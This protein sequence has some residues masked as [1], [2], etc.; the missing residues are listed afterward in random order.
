MN[1]RIPDFEDMKHEND[2][3]VTSLVT[4]SDFDG[5]KQVS[6][7]GVEYWSARDVRDLLKY[8]AWR[9]FLC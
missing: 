8:T 9:S 2:Q 6:S 7:Q 1:L 4:F 5:I 3:K